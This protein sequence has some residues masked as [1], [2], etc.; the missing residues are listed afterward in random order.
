GIAVIVV[1]ITL[2]KVHPFLAL[3]GGGA[4]VGIVAGESIPTVLDSFTSG[5]GSTAA[6][7][8]ILIGKAALKQLSTSC[9]AD[10]IPGLWVPADQELDAHR[11]DPVRAHRPVAGCQE[12]RR[13]AAHRTSQA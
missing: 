5:F 2:A 10:I 9:I 12:D 13:R 6:G 1:A 4:T 3:V 8:G 7:V 11:G